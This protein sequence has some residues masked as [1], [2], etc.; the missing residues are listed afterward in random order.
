MLLFIA[1]TL[2]IVKLI[3][4]TKATPNAL[5]V[6]SAISAPDQLLVLKINQFVMSG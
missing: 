6:T 2:T 4:F 1:P 3:V 5:V